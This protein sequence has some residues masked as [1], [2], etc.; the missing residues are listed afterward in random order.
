MRK[1]ISL[2]RDV[3]KNY[4]LKTKY[5]KEEK[6][7]QKIHFLI[8]DEEKNINDEILLNDVLVE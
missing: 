3:N 6:Y 1:I 2:V 4:V 5:Y 7:P 8:G